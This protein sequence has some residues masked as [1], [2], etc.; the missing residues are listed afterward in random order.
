M[1]PYFNDSIDR[2]LPASMPNTDNGKRA[3]SATA[4]RGYEVWGTS[5]QARYGGIIPS[6][7]LDCPS[8]CR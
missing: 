6:G 5:L 1:K 3:N 8:M 7:L 2:K 4:V